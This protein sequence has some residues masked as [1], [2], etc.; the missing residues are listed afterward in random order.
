MEFKDY[1]KILGVERN[2]SIEEIKKAYRKLAQKYHPDRNPGN[3][4]A[5]EKFKEINEAHEVLSDPEKR[6]KYDNLGTSWFNFQQQGG[7]ADQFNWSDWF[8]YEPVGT[9][10]SRRTG[11]SYL[12]EI[13]GSGGTF[14]DF[15]EKIFGFDFGY[16]TAPKSQSYQT[17]TSKDIHYEIQINLEEAFKGTTKIIEIHNKKIEVKIKPGI[18]DGQMLKIPLKSVL[19][20]NYNGDLLITV[21]VLPH[22][23]VERKGDD[24]YVD[25]PIDIFKLILG[26]ESKIKTFGGLIKFKIPPKSQNGTILKLKGQGMPKYNNPNERGDLYLK[27][28]AKIPENLTEKEM[29]LIQEIQNSREK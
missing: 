7:R 21:K 2:A 14:S 28:I 26:G 12:D 24:L 20:N 22:K 23:K 29:K 17:K 9:K 25:V 27:L 6:R 5:E 10:K 16:K 15:F 8:A 18:I 1:Y 19:G 3:K 13:L 11:F 4:E